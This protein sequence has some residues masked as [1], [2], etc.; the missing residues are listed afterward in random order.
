VLEL[1]IGTGRVGLPLAARGLRVDG[2][3][4]STE[5]IAK[6]RAKPGGERLDITVGDVADVPVAGRYLTDD[7]GVRDRVLRP[8]PIPPPDRRPV[9]GPRGWPAEFDTAGSTTHVS[10][11]GR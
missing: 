4:A 8:R 3:E 7:G 9:D 11:Y 1:A 6:L 5:M 2:V 10:V